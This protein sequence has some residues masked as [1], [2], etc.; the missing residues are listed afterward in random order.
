MKVVIDASVWV[1]SA[2]ADEK[3]YA[4]SVAFIQRVRHERAEVLCPWLVLAECAAAIIRPTNNVEHADNLIGRI[5]HFPNMTLKDIDESLVHE[6]VDIVRKCGLRGADSVY[7]AL[8]KIEG[9]T[10]V[11]WDK[12]FF[13]EKATEIVKALNPTQWLVANP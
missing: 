5:E 13:A 10:L 6:A 1:A 11:A 2:N 4:V 8:A 9:A 12:A 7:A 3:D